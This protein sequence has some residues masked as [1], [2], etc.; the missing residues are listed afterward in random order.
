MLEVRK[1]YDLTGWG[2]GAGSPSES[3]PGIKINIKKT[4][5]MVIRRKPKKIDMR[6]KDESVELMDSFKYLNNAGTDKEEANKLLGHW[7]KTNCLLKDA[8][9]GMVNGKNVRGRR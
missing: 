1:P 9:E 6:I 3:A 4:K 5:A 7:L 2:D 8:P